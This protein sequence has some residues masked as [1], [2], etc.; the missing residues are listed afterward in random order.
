MFIFQICSF[1]VFY[2]KTTYNTFYHSIRIIPFALTVPF[3][4]PDIRSIK[5]YMFMGKIRIGK[6]ILIY[7][8]P[9]DTGW[10]LCRIHSTTVKECKFII[11][12]LLLY[13]IIAPLISE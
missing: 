4:E 3:A 6:L 12:N 5:L 10:C 9:Y 7:Y 8:F 11:G 2:P 13:R 1:R